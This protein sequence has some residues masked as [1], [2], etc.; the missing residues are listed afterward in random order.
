[1]KGKR[2]SQALALAALAAIGC[3][4]W[5][6]R[7]EL[8]SVELASPFHL[9]LCALSTVGYLTANGLLSYTMI[10]KLGTRIGILECLSLSVVTAGLNALA[11][12]QGG[13]VGRAVYLKRFHNFEYSRFL[14]T[15]IGCQVLMMIVCSVL[16]A[17]ALMWM[18]FM[19][20]RFELGVLGATTLCLLVSMLLCFMPRISAKGN[21]LFDGVAA[22]SISWYRL[23][24]QPQF[25]ATLTAFVGLQVGSQLL[26]FWT[27]CAA[28]GIG[29]GL[30]EAT[31][32]G[33]LGTL[34]SILSITPGALGIYEAAVA[35]VAAAMA[36]IPAAQIIVAALVSRAVLLVL[37]LIL[38]P[39]AISFLQ[40]KTQHSPSSE[41][42][43]VK[44]TT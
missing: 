12:V 38:T 42:S 15:L 5:W 13:M 3:Y 18:W 33:T 2:L 6:R 23:R 24:A 4:L 43:S 26:S 16:A 20:H 36:E 41:S 22:V 14:A 11:P 21:W 7:A 28:I 37:L 19:E 44:R 27:A 29:L 32:V 25:L 35:F 30:V 1:M 39:P 8:A 9:V 40:R 17:A 10:N 31:I 34:A